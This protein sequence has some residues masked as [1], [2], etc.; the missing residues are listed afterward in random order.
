ME[1]HDMGSFRSRASILLAAP[2]V[3]VA[4][5]AAPAG[6]TNGSDLQVTLVDT[7]VDPGGASGTVRVRA[8]RGEA[9]LSLRLR[10]V[11]A[12][13]PLH[14]CAGEDAS[15][16]ALRADLAA[17]GGTLSSE[18]G[19]LGFDPR[20]L[21]LAVSAAG[22]C[23]L[24]LL[25]A[26]L[27][28]PDDCAAVSRVKIGERTDLEPG[29]ATP[30]AS[31]E[32]LYMLLPDRNCRFAEGGSGKPLR[33]ARLSVRVKHAEPHAIYDVCVDDVDR[34]PLATNAAGV[35][36]A[37]FSYSS[38]HGKN[39]HKAVIDFDAYGSH[40]E[41]RDDGDCTGDDTTAVFFGS[42]LAPLCS[43]EALA[44]ELLVPGASPPATPAGQVTFE[45][46]ER[47][48]RALTV[49]VDGLAPST[50]YDVDVDP[51]DLVVEGFAALVTDASGD[52]QVVFRGEPGPGELPLDFDPAVGQAV[53]VRPTTTA[54][55]ALSG[56]L[57]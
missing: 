44:A 32:L 10:N 57:E 25:E 2:L 40:F 8:Q 51:T 53:E 11:D 56:T 35:G 38:G 20:G 43:E 6:A 24:P 16:L 52:A 46:D 41:I 29:T 5:D 34:G 30:P 14:L 1:V 36:R 39:P 49:F 54:T 7:G 12:S 27:D 37:E 48:A 45:R 50:I 9:S 47:C 28:E 18:D 4:L 15:S 22:D 3:V 13:P 31:A 17:S 23:S 19:T 42:L 26:E 55:V 21:L 33:K